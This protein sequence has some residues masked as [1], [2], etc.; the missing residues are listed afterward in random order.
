[1]AHTLQFG[2]ALHNAGLVRW[3]N[4]IGTIV[5][6]EQRLAKGGGMNRSVH[7][8]GVLVQERVAVNGHFHDG[9]YV[10][11]VCEHCDFACAHTKSFTTLSDYDRA[12]VTYP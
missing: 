7:A 9:T 11:N 8:H 3:R 5:R 12:C 2:N 6:I 4:W 10:E 1:M